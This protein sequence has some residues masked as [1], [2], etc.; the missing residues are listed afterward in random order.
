MNLLL[1]STGVPQ[2]TAPQ[3]S[4]YKIIFPLKSEQ[5]KIASFLSTVDTK[6]DQLTQKKSLLETYKKGAMQKIFSQQ[7]RFKADDGEDYPEWEAQSLEFLAQITMGSSPKSSAYNNSMN[8]LPL[9]QGNADIYK[10]QSSPRIYTSEITKECFEDDILLSV[11][12][13]VGEVSRSIHHACIGRGIAAIRA[14][15]QTNNDFLYQFLLWFEPKWA[16]VSQ[17]STFEAVNSKDI[18][19]L[20][21]LCPCL[22]EQTKIANFL[23]AIDRKI[24]LVSQQL[25]QAKAFKKGLLQQMFV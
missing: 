1:E 12:A 16:G 9:I 20:S 18:R 19:E 17:G 2:L 24:D 5:T 4:N 21:I 15:N 25:E 14:K 11:R 8:G 13:P 23:S 22:E 7:I 6:I 10:R 3:I